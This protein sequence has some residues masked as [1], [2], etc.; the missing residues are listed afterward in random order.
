MVSYLFLLIAAKS[1]GQRTISQLR[2]LDF[3]IALI[4][5]NI[6][7]QPLSDERLGL[8]GSM[9]C[10]II[11]VILYIFTS[12]LSLKWHLLQR[13]FDPPPVL[14]IE[15]G[16]IRLK[17][18]GKARISIEHLFSELRKQQVDDISKVAL[19]LWEPGG[20][21]S[22]FIEPSHQPLTPMDMSLSPQ[23][24]SLTWPLIMDGH[25]NTHILQHIGKD[26][27][28]LQS[29]LAE[30]GTDI[31]EIA[32]ATVDQQDKLSIHKYAECSS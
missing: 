22:M 6:I 32:L 16:Q 27:I 11:L 15:H 21:I 12:W 2:F 23:P 9:I 29:K 3:I 13:Y 24:F 26:T 4:L 8:I 1:M 20:T 25:I 18:L 17:N 14:L 10:T 19:A 28:W 31:K 30:S 7:A 5:G